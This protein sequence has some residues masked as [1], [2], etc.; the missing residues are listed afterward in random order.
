MS[1]TR[2]AMTILGLD[3]QATRLGYGLCWLDDG[4]PLPHGCGCVT[5]Q[6]GI[7]DADAVRAALMHVRSLSPSIR[8]VYVEAPHVGLSRQGSVIHAMSVGRVLQQAAQF[9]P[10]APVQ[11]MQPSEWKKLVDLPG[12]ARKEQIALRA[13]ALGFDHDSQDALDAGCIAVAGFR[14]NQEILA[15]L[16]KAAT[17]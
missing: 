16:G 15:S 9:W 3:A 10:T 8:L 11:M 1:I 5:Y 2:Q 7:P 14:R 12:N 17:A 4:D 13:R 6:K